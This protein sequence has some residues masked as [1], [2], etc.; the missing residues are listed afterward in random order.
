[1]ICISCFAANL[2][3]TSSIPGFGGLIVMEVKCRGPCIYIYVHARD[4]Q[5]I[6]FPEPYSTTHLVIVL[7]FLAPETKTLAIV[8]SALYSR[9]LLNETWKNQENEFLLRGVSFTE[10]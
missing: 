8:T 3:D 7:L 2:K 4:S 9:L 5:V 1:M 6:K 10:G